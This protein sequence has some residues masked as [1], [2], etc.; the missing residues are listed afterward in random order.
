MRRSTIAALGALLCVCPVFS[1]AADKELLWGDTHLHTSYSFDA[2]INDNLTA[3]PDTAYR[4]AKGVPVIHPGHGA[5]VQIETPLDF[6][7]VSDHAEFLGV[8]RHTFNEG[9]RDEGLGPIEYVKALV[10]QYLV[11]EAIEEKR[12]RPFF[13]SVL[14]EPSDDATAAA[15]AWRPQVGDIPPQMSVQA[16]AWGEIVDAADRH[17]RP[18]EFTA[19]IGWEFSPVPGGAN[20]HRIVVSDI[21]AERA[22]GFR[23]FSLVDSIYP[24]DLWQWLAQ[25][26]EATGAD[27]IAIPHNSNIS[28]GVMFDTKTLRGAPL[29]AEYAAVRR[30]WEPIV[31]VTQIKGDSE[32]HPALSPDDEFADFEHYPFYIQREFTEYRP[33]EGDFA[34]SALK[35]GLSFE[36]SL[37]INPFQFGMIGSTDSHTGLSSAEERNFHGKMASDGVPA[38]K[39]ATWSDDARGT[40]GWAMSASGLAAVWAEENTREAI[41][42]AMRRREVYATTGPR[43][44]VRLHAGWD[45][46]AADMQDSAYPASLDARAVPMG[47]EL[48][49]G[50]KGAAPV[51]LIESTADP[52]SGTLDRVQ[53]IKGWIEE[54]GST[55]EQIYNVA[56]AG[57]EVRQL[58][59]GSLA[60]IEGTVNLSTGDVDLSAGVPSLSTVWTDPDF[61]PRQAAFYYVRVLEIPTARHSLLDRL[62]LDDSVET[63]RPDTLQERAYTSPVWYRPAP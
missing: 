39:T 1:H 46:E 47:G 42:A 19:L 28:K 51:L 6:L 21:D 55:R 50:P 12:G 34:R 24:E 52:L 30:Q 17:N 63:Q 3:D 27:F 13:V 41:V 32:T 48:T 18:G 49:A 59:D 29:D 16:D 25:T 56:W 23:P 15:A 7:V 4:Y 54:D 40:F 38:K 5:R 61:D 11:R 58:K 44:G 57:G 35:R 10:A 45:L 33:T 31:E 36:R 22:K 26:S 2:F 60:P 53:V 14:P 43:I 62:A 37:G 8:I 20:L 9:F